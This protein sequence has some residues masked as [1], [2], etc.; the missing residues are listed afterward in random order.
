M[1][2][3]ICKHIK[4]K[5]IFNKSI[6]KSSYIYQK[7]FRSIYGYNQAVYKKNNK[8]YVYFREGILSF[9]PYIKSEKNS[10]IIPS[11]YED[12]L[13]NYFETGINPTHNWRMKGDWNVKY[14]INNIELDIVNISLGVEKFIKNYNVLSNN[15]KAY[16]YIEIELNKIINNN[17]KDEK[18]LS[19]L[20]KKLENIFNFE[21]V[22]ESIN[23]SDF[24]KEIYTKYQ[25]IIQN[26]NF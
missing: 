11:G 21:W 15:F 17:V 7:V 25:K 10:V 4:Y 1:N 20:I 12:K 3:I 22:Y 26:T 9:I 2:K 13:I 5:F 6:T 18:Y 16:N 23:Y 14:E 8:K 19:Y 24:I